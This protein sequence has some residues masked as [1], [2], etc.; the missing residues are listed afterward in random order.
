MLLF[1]K[2]Q[3]CKDFCCPLIN[4]TTEAVPIKNPTYFK[5]VFEHN[6]SKVHKE[7]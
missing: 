6:D 5:V 4:L 2:M 7:E 1:A 3:Y